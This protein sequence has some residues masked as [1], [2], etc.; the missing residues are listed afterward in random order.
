MENWSDQLHLLALVLAIGAA[1]LAGCSWWFSRAKTA[2]KFDDLVSARVREMQQQIE[3]TAADR[4]KWLSVMQQLANDA[5]ESLD[6]AEMARRR[7]AAT[8]SRG[9]KREEKEAEPA[10]PELQFG[11]LPRAQ[12]LTA[13]EQHFRNG[14]G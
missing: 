6:R 1:T 4:T 2:R 7:A 13:I 5:A 12:Q 10:Q 9:R 3:D 8:E 11:E 14:R